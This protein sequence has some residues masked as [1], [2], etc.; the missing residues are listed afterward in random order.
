MKKN[1]FIA[2]SILYTFFLVFLTLFVGLIANYMHNRVL[3]GR[4]EETSREVLAKINNTKLNDLKVGDHIQ[5]QTKEALING[6]AVWTVARIDTVGG[7]KKYYFISDLTAA[8]SNVYYQLVGDSFPK[9]HPLTVAAFNQLVTDG[10]LNAE[11]TNGVYN[12]HEVT[13]SLLTHIRN[14]VTDPFVLDELMNP[15][16]SYLVYVD[17]DIDVYL[18]NNYYE[19]KRYNFTNSDQSSLLPNYCGGT[20]NGIDPEYTA[21]NTFGYMNVDNEATKET[22]KFISYCYYSS[23]V[24]Y[25]HSVSDHVV[26]IDENKE[27]DILP[28]MTSNLY[29]YR[30][31]AER[32]ISNSEGSIYISGGKGTSLDPYIYTNGVKQS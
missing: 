14:N 24:P 22:K 1:G 32:T 16:G 17:D 4:I 9:M 13:S 26:M 12:V 10:A 23:P 8:P 3:L 7:G 15:G 5:F 21:N 29:T 20:F 28:T 25:T 18:K 6:S 19:I 11:F 30:L 27:S 2:T 31:V